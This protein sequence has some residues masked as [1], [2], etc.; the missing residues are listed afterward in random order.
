MATTTIMGI[1]AP[2]PPA[3]GVDVEPTAEG[4]VAPQPTEYPRAPLPAGLAWLYRQLEW[5]DT[6]ERLR[7]RHREMAALNALQDSTARASLLGAGEG[8]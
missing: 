3:A 4:N 2:A 8:T 6:L 7:A 5:E 1:R